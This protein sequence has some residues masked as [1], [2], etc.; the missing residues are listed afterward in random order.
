MTI[1]YN[2]DLLDSFIAPEISRFDRFHAPDLVTAHP[3]APHWLSNHFLNSVFRGKFQNKIRQYAVNQLYR[4][5]VSFADYH[6][7][8][9]LTKTFLSK[10]TPHNPSVKAY[11]RALARWE[12]CM[13]NVQIFADVVNKMR[14]DLGDDPVF[15]KDDGTPEQRAYEIANTIKHFGKDVHSGRHRE[16]DT[17]P[18][19]LTNE[20]LQTRT[21]QLLYQELA[22][23]IS[24]IAT[25]ADHLQDP[26]KFNSR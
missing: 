19:W 11:F 15:E 10:G 21:H 9:D 6:Q 24:A 22:D 20:G 23:L 2:P 8:V 5:Q 4:A 3:E 13:L 25:I 12:S 1:A 7:A 17:V 26:S 18:M 14:V 16:T